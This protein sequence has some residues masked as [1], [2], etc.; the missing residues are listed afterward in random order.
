[1]EARPTSA[2]REWET[3]FPVLGHLDDAIRR[4]R[5]HLHRVSLPP[6]TV[7][8][9]PGA[10]CANYLMVLKG[11]VR[12]TLTSSSGR[13]IVLYHVAEGETCILTTSCLLA[14]ENYSAFGTTE[15]DVEALL[16]SHSEFNRAIAASEAF[17]SFVFAG[18]GHRFSELIDR[19]DQVSFRS[20]ETRLAEALIA[21]SHDS[22]IVKSTHQGLATELG[23]ARE[24]VSRHLKQFELQGYIQLRRGH[25]TLQQPDE[26][27]RLA[28]QS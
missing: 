12:V 24:V 1:M 3:A 7:V 5:D 6:Q 21:M 28:N 17:R 27:L 26:L 14:S 10:P 20:V 4:L 2:N 15:T 13:E 16:L 19:I 11:T 25:I 23:T 8:F 9:Q 18:L 22:P